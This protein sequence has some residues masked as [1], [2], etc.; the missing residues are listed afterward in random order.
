MMVGSTVGSGTSFFK[1]PQTEIVDGQRG[2][3]S[4]WS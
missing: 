4:K 2:A 3:V 1:F